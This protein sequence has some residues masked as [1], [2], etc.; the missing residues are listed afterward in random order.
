M[1]LSPAAL[2]F[3]REKALFNQLSADNGV[4]K[5]IARIR[6]LSSGWGFGHR[7]DLLTGA[8][9][10]TR[11]MSPEIADS[12]AQCR[13][14][15]GFDRPV[16]IYV[17]PDPMV[18]AC[19]MKNPTGPVLVV[20]SSRMIEVFTPAELR[21]VIGH[22]LGHATFDHFSIPMPHTAKI[23][24]MGVPYVSRKTSLELYVWCRA[25][26]LSADRIGMVC[27]QDP[28]AAAS[29]FFKCASGLSSERVKTD[30]ETYSR[31]IESLASAPNARAEPRDDDDTLDCFSTHP[32]SPVRVRAVVAFSKSKGYLDA[33]GKTGAS[34]SDDDI[35]AVIE[36]DLAMMEPNYLEEKSSKSDVLKRVLYSAG[37]CVAAANGKIDDRELE[38]MA[39]LLGTD[40]DASKTTP[41]TAKKDLDGRIK[42]AVEKCT[43]GER[44]QVVQHLTIIAAAD[45]I[46]E[47]A[48]VSE[49]HRISNALGVDVMV[50]EQTLRGAAWPMD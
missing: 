21:F 36:R 27:A 6:E 40:Y 39:M 26:E 8:L 19:C 24:E 45:G 5:A 38:S 49:M 47:P 32:Y 48:E 18:N 10:L 34:L 33:I 41:E 15:I 4:K 14:I 29:G 20:V 16:E 13:E 30:L 2:Q 28:Q 37:I 3:R 25:A 46:V 42:E 9:R 12:L 1:A 22:E 43:L 23:E 11:S 50:I 35:D 31:Q 7:R 44:A 17:R